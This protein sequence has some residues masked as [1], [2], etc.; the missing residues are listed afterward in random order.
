MTRLI[1]AAAFII[2][3]AVTSSRVRM[4]QVRRSGLSINRRVAIRRSTA[5]QAGAA[6]P[7]VA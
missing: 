5:K 2:A 6:Q 7:L 4:E 3:A 1:A